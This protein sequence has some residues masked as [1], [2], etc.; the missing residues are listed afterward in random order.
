MITYQTEPW[1]FALYHEAQAMLQGHWEEV[2]LD[3]DRIKLAINLETYDLIDPKKLLICTVRDAE[4]LIGYFA[5]FLLLAGDHPHYKNDIFAQTDVYYV[6]PEYRLTRVPVRLFQFV[7]AECG[8]RGV[9]KMISI[10]KLHKDHSRL[11]EFLGWRPVETVFAKV[12]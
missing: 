8:K 2:A 12:L 3:K 1:S 7:E 4:K 6:L 10:T 5:M 9:A 11:F